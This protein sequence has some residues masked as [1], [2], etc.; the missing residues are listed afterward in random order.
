[1]SLRRF[2]IRARLAAQ[3]VGFVVFLAVVAVIGY[4]QIADGAAAAQSLNRGRLL[5]SAAQTV[6]FDFADLNGWQNAYAFSAARQ[7]PAGAV[8]TAANRKQ[9]LVVAARTRTDLGQLLDL[10]A[11]TTDAGAADQRQ[12]ATTA[13]DKFEQFMTVDA[14]IAA[15]YRLR[16]AASAIAADD[17]VNNDEVAIYDA[18]AGAVNDLASR[19]AKQQDATAASTTQ[20]GST[21]RTTI[22]V[23]ALLALLAAGGA[24]IAITASIATPLRRLR[25][26]LEGIAHGDGDLTARLDVAGRDELTEVS[27]LFNTFVEQIADTVRDVAASAGTLAAA[28]EQLTGNAGVIAAASE[29]ASA[30]AGVV[31]AASGHL[32]GSVDGFSMAA[33]ELGQSIGEIAQNASAAA[34]VAATAVELAEQTTAT[35]TTLGRSSAEISGV[36]AMITGVA[37][38]TNLLALNA[39]IEAARAGDA[40]KGFAVV[41]SEVKDLAQETARATGDIT[42]RIEQIQAE[43]SAAVTAIDQIA[44][45]IAQINDYQA[46]I[47]GAVEQQ[48][49]TAAQLNSTVADAASNTRDI[50]SNIVGVADA[51]D[52]T[53]RSVGECQQAVSELARMSAHLQQTVTRFRT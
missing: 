27:N 7:G 34:R 30:Q 16:G 21:S 8:D 46:S 23:T 32:S 31:A 33:G 2:G 22:V 41:A 28:T 25:D 39:T 19:L 18:G 4:I 49:A 53:A 10:L 47:A 42:A 35:V 48:T 15:L 26:R 12:L 36:V 11:A 40:G 37:G 29:E 43:T 5:Q 51:A 14:K 9:F 6:Q 45:V 3:A 17:L 1:M 20:A 13:R 50:S 44:Q 38:Q 24:A 52:S